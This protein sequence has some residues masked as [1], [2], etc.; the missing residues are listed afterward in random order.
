[1]MSEEVNDIWDSIVKAVYCSVCQHYEDETNGE[2]PKMNHSMRACPARR[3][4]DK[5]R[6]KIKA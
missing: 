4:A 3:A 5:M 2:C 6:M 1:M